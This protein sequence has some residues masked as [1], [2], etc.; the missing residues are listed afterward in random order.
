MARTVKCRQFEKALEELCTQGFESVREK[1]MMLFLWMA[2]ME[3][4]MPASNP[5]LLW[6][7][8]VVLAY[9]LEQGQPMQ[10]IPLMQGTHQCNKKIW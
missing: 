7:D 2:L 8:F 9:V 4:S 5:N 3:K 1:W 10:S 6:K